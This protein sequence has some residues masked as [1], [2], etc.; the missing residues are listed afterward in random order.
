MLRVV[1]EK[2]SETN[3]NL[4][5]LQSGKSQKRWQQRN[6]YTINDSCTFEVTL[7]VDSIRFEC[8]DPPQNPGL[9]CAFITTD[10]SI[11]NIDGSA[12]STPVLVRENV[13]NAIDEAT[14]TGVIH[15]L[16]WI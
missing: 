16:F 6:T 2:G 5:H 12:I 1:Q 14:D 11:T 10:I 9:Q 15:D 8:I 4:L 13:Q 7:R 3:L